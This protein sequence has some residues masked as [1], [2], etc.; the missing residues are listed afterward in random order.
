MS[1]DIAIPTA[2]PRA[3]TVMRQQITQM[4]H[5]FAIAS[6]RGVEAAQ[7]VRDALTLLRQTPDLALCTPRSVLGGLM[8]MAQLGLRPGVL[9]H[10]WLIPFKNRTTGHKEATLVI[11][12]QGLVELAHRSGRI[13]RITAHTVHAND[14]F[15]IE[16][17]TNERLVHRPSAGDRGKPTGYYATVT[18]KGGDTAFYYMSHEEMLVYRDRYAMSKKGPW[19]DNFEAMAKKTC[20]R[21]LSKLM[22][23]GTDL[24][25][26]LAV[27]DSVRIDITPDADPAGV[28]QHYEVIHTDGPE[29]TAEDFTAA[30][31][32]AAEPDGW[33][34][35]A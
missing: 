32:S 16:Y 5:Q 11:G 12:Y 30:T 31:E 10:G 3:A 6:P 14:H 22:P 24:A 28:S 13:S 15:D 25:V 29:A 2:E 23:K 9:G 35:D 20:V 8:T 33:V 4:E 26:A 7:L 27:D 19:A 1:N 34:R 21:Q 18:I 17:G